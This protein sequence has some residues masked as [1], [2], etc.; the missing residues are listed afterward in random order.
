LAGSHQTRSL[1][2]VATTRPSI[3]GWW[4]PFRIEAGRTAMTAGRASER[5]AESSLAAGIGTAVFALAV[6][7]GTTAAEAGWPAWLAV[8]TSTLIF[9]GGAQF[10]LVL[11]LAGGGGIGGALLA[12]IMVNLRFIPMTL[13]AASSLHGG[14]LRR[15]LEAQAVVD[16]SWVGAR[17]ADGSIDRDRMIRLSLVQW[18][19]WIAGTAV[20]AVLTPGFEL[21]RTVGLDTIF[22]AFF[23]VFVLDALRDERRHRPVIVA[24]SLITS[25]MCW[26]VPPGAALLA[27]GAAA[28]LVMKELRRR[29]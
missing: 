6:S 29:S 16:A 12:A 2:A 11:A 20:G 9:A 19:A 15:S 21:S 26:L 25:A 22:P 8:M 1:L 17:R 10:A 4:Q 3:T 27:A 14:R 23:L 7:F 13:T 18:P 24:A 5:R 28:L